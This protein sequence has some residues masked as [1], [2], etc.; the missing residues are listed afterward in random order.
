MRR[1]VSVFLCLFLSNVIAIAQDY[2]EYKR[3]AF[4]EYES[5]KQTAF[6]EFEAYR[7][8]VNAE[9]AEFLG[10]P[11]EPKQGEKPVPEPRKPNIPPVVMPEIGVDIPED[12]PIDVNVNFPKLDA[13]PKPIAPVA[14]R[15]KPD[16]KTLS[17]A[18]YGTPG[19]VRFDIDKKAHLKGADEKAVSAFWKEL[20]GPAYDNVV[21]DCQRIRGE[22]DLCDWAYFKA[23]EKL[24]ETLYKSRN[25]RAV[26]LAWLLT[27]SGFSM[28]LGLDKANLY[29]LLGTSDMLFGKL[30]WKMEDGYYSLMGE[31]RVT[32]L[33][34]VDMTFPGTS[35]LRMRM[36]AGN[37]LAENASAGRDLQSRRYP[38]AAASVACDKNRLAFY[39]DFPAAAIGGTGNTNFMVYADMPL[40]E[41]AGKNLYRCLFEQV[42]GK[43]EA[44][45]ANILLNFVQTAFD[46][47]TDG[48]VWGRERVF[49]PEETLYYPYCDC[50]DRSILFS[51]LVRD[52]MGLET[53]FVLYPGHLA[54][55][56]HFTTDI[57]GDYF[58]IGE[59]RY[60]VCD[61]TYINASI[62]RTMPGMDNTTAQ[63]YVWE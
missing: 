11:W 40:S 23:L 51:R 37:I 3:K 44:E 4:S 31:E 38:E 32:S 39:E 45:V 62:G 41:S 57:P 60:L 34:M 42:A 18:F 61:P 8:K 14:Y 48:E 21:A 59:K 10:K 29:L 24:T 53:A 63:V 46:Y 1:K 28:R 13:E 49:F 26:F 5:Y 22:L 27:Q 56:V 36:P 55:A 12:R 17:F 9:F 2:N 54:T 19:S 47:K 50:E 16:E 58:I 20:S 15:P 30:F 35:P 25:E 52:I 43:T 7:R 6:E 33:K